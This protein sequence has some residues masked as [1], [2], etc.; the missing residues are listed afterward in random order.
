[1]REKVILQKYGGVV[2]TCCCILD[3]M[4][5]IAS[6]FCDVSRRSFKYHVS[7]EKAR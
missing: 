1:M 4:L 7:Y 2:V 6:L 5:E 3:L